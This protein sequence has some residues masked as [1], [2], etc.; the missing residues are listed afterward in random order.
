MTV[1]YNNDAS[2]VVLQGSYKRTQRLAVKKIGRFIEYQE[3][4]IVP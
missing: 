1:A 3:M 4:W 2:F